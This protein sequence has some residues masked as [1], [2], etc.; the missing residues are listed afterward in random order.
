MASRCD[1][2]IRTHAVK[3]CEGVVLTLT[4]K[5]PDSLVKEDDQ[6]LEIVPEQHGFLKVDKLKEDGERVFQQ[7]LDFLSS[8]SITR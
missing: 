5:T 7:I 8:Q 1:F 4:F 2:S 6:S 3:F